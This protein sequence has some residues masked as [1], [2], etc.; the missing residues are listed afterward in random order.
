MDLPRCRRRVRLPLQRQQTSKTMKKTTILLAVA[1]LALNSCVTTETTVTA[2]DGTVTVTKTTSPD[3]A[4][5]TAASH[6]VDTIGA[7]SNDK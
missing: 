1:L 7:V 3:G 2:P 6:A 4:S 5:V